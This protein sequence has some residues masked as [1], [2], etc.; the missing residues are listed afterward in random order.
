MLLAENLLLAAVSG[1]ASSSPKSAH[2]PANIYNAT[3]GAVIVTGTVA[4]SQISTTVQIGKDSEAL[5]E[6]ERLIKAVNISVSL[7]DADL[8]ATLETLD[9]IATQISESPDRRR[10]GG[11]LRTLWVGL[12]P[13][14]SVCGDATQIYLAISPAIR[15]ILQRM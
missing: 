11:V 14:L 1:V 10:K 2:S 6:L 5:A 8:K 12:Q 4:A 3:N 15:E 13:M 9:F 7:A